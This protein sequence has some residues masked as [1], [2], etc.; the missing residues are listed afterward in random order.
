[1][2]DRVVATL[3]RPRRARGDAGRRGEAG[4]DAI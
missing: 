4:R 1:M 3:A 2:I